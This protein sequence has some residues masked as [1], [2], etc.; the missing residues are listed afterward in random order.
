MPYHGERE[1]DQ[2]SLFIQNHTPGFI[3]SALNWFGESDQRADARL[4]ARGHSQASIDAA[5]AE[6]ERYATTPIG[7]Q[8]LLSKVAEATNIDPRIVQTGSFLLTS[9]AEGKA[10]LNSLKIGLNNWA[11]TTPK[12]KPAFA[13]TPKQAL[14]EKAKKAR[15]L[16]VDNNQFPSRSNTRP[17]NFRGISGDVQGGIK[18]QPIRMESRPDYQVAATGLPLGE[19]NSKTTKNFTP[20]HRTGIQ[21]NRAFM[22]GKT[23]PEAATRRAELAE[24]GLILGNTGANY[25]PVFDGV[26]STKATAK[27]GIKSHDHDQIHKRSDEL[28]ARMGIK[29]DRKNRDN[30]T[31]HG[32]PI[33]DLPNEVQRD[34]QIA[35]GM[36][37]ELI[38]DDVQFKRFQA[39][40][41]K[42]GHLPAAE[43]RRIIL[44]EP[45]RFASLSTHVTK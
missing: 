19:F 32:T 39:F 2:A 17:A 5:N 27:T 22:V 14:A 43:Q 30:D 6:R 18:G 12:A 38:I 35:L 36:Q 23:G 16:M 31:W 15:D 4:L 42:F 44:E 7:T 34:L 33:K 21:D 28:R 29:N 37:D 9:F 45:E 26:K 25:Q 20:H 11:R 40:K 41:K 24:G 10:G 13:L 8:K 3:K 1:L